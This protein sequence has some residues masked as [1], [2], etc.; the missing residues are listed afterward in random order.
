MSALAWLY[1]AEIVTPLPTKDHFAL[2]GH[3]YQSQALLAAPSASPSRKNRAFGGFFMDLSGP[4]QCYF[5]DS[6]FLHF[7]VSAGHMDQPAH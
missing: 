2:S 5:Q 1:H 6:F 4:K 3:F 7:S